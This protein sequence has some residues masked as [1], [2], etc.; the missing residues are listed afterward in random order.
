MS[1]CNTDAFVA[2]LN[3]ADLCGETADD[4]RLPTLRELLG[5]VHNG[6]TTPPAIDANYFSA[7]Q[8]NWYWTNDTYQLYSGYALVVRFSNGQSG[9]I[10]KSVSNYV[11]LVR[12]GQ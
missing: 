8:S 9:A 10:D 12:S 5:I 6:M 2:A 11:R 3:A 1:L 4:W 7:T